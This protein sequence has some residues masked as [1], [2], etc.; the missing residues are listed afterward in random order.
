MNL[1]VVPLSFLEFDVPYLR[2]DAIAITERDLAPQFDHYRFDTNTP[3][4][5]QVFQ[6]AADGGNLIFNV[7]YT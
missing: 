5:S 1:S 3:L 6:I 4:N 7:R 2:R